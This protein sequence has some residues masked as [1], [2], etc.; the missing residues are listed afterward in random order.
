MSRSFEVTASWDDEAQVWVAT[1]EDVLGLVTEARSLDDL[2]ARVLAV[3]PELL[4]DNGIA[5]TEADVDFH[6]VSPLNQTAAE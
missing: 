4:R 6:I 3:T 1:S 2:Y 5:A